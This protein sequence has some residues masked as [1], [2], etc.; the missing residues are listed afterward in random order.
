MQVAAGAKEDVP[1]DEGGREQGGGS[2]DGGVRAPWGWRCAVCL[3]GGGPQE[4]AFI[5]GVIKSSTRP[6]G[7]PSGDVGGR[8]C[9]NPE[10]WGTHGAGGGDL[11]AAACEALGHMS[12]GMMC[13]GERMLPTPGS[14]ASPLTESPS[15]EHLEGWGWM[16]SCAQHSTCSLRP[17]RE[18]LG[19]E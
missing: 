14:G 4:A 18:S 9:T 1:V 3:L 6:F 5:R 17:F 13:S 2:Q 19:N 8:G 10:F 12:P 11:A 7:H 16:H 15:W